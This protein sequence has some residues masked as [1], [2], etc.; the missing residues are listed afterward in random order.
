MCPAYE[1]NRTIYDQDHH[2]SYEDFSWWQQC[3][4]YDSIIGLGAKQNLPFPEIS[5]RVSSDIEYKSF[6]G[7]SACEQPIPCCSWSAGQ[8][9]R[10]NR[11]VQID[12][13]TGP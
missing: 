8:E 13:F 4:K 12:L 10:K 2:Q 5:S 3:I 6:I 1:T 7:K 11:G 9:K